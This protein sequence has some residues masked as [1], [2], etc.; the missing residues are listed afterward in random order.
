MSTRANRGMSLE[1]LI[2]HAN[3]QYMSQ[4]MAVIHKRPTPVKIM[5]TQGTRI[6]AAVLESK[7]TVDYE[8]VYR[9]RSLQF[10]AKQTKVETR[11]DLDNIHEH[12]V[13][14][15][16]ACERQGAVTFIIME[17]TK[18]NQIFYVPGKMVVEAWL[19]AARGG[20]RSITYDDISAMCYVL[21]SGRGVVLDYL[22]VV[23]RII[24]QT[25]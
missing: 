24:E 1:T 25:A 2:N 13:S 21:Q 12:Q 6:T 22:A 17:F 19:E 9:G 20:R 14:H 3:A 16:R 23:D 8:G 15:I 4:G 5:R 11:F 10:E 18:R 7:S